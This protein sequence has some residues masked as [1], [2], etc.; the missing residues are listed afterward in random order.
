MT[1]LKNATVKEEPEI[2]KARFKYGLVLI[3]L[4]L[5]QQEMGKANG[6]QAKSHEE[7]DEDSEAR[8]AESL[9][10]RIAS[11]TRAIAPILLP[12]INSLGAMDIEDIKAAEYSGEMN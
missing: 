1:E 11:T 9:E 12:M 4:G 7:N 8:I 3:G 2:I 10:G 5:L 6:S